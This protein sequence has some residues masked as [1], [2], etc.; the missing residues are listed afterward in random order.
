MYVVFVEH[1]IVGRITLTAFNSYKE[2]EEANL[3]THIEGN[4]V[5]VEYEGANTA[6]DS[7][8]NNEKPVR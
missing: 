5:K 6:P 1:P 2:Y 8:I 7:I 3:P 4:L